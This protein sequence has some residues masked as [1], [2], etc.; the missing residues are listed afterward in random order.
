MIID[1]NDYFKILYLETELSE[2]L[3]RRVLENYEEELNEEETQLRHARQ[4]DILI[5]KLKKKKQKMGYG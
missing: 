4:R 5:T 1:V 2:D 3:L